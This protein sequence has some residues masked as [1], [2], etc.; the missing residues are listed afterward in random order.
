MSTRAPAGLL[1]ALVVTVFAVFALI[2]GARPAVASCLGPTVTAGALEV[3][4]GG[5]LEVVGQAFGDN[6]Y[7]TGAPPAGEGVLGHPQEDIQ[8]LLVQ[9]ATEVLV[10]KGDADDAFAFAVEVVV[11][12]AFEPGGV[13]LIARLAD[14][15]DIPAR[16]AAFEPRTI[17]ITEAPP[18]GD[19]FVV[20]SFEGADQAPTDVTL[21]G[22]PGTVTTV[23]TPTAEPADPDGGPP[24]ELLGAAALAVA[25]AAAVLIGRRRTP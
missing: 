23:A 5:T 11:P 9:G 13:Q 15:Q 16:D 19:A 24:W 3:V 25:V 10:A 4:R 1:T 22:E 12:P 18:A 17:T 20:A 14:G 21:A 8:I 2:G 6:C 7:D